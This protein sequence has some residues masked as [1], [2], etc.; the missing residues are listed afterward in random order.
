[1]SLPHHKKVST[2]KS[3]FAIVK[4]YCEKQVLVIKIFVKNKNLLTKGLKGM[5]VDLGSK[6]IPLISVLVENTKYSS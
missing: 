4:H 5:T 3:E 2:K 1:M 6:S